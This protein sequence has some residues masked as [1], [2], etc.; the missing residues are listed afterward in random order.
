MK[1][2]KFFS[3]SPKNFTSSN[4][5][6]TNSS[7][8]VTY[9]VRKKLAKD[10]LYFGLTWI[11]SKLLKFS[12]E[13]HCFEQFVFLSLFQNY[14]FNPFRQI[15]ETISKKRAVTQG[16]SRKLFPDFFQISQFRIM[17]QGILWKLF[18][19]HF[20]EYLPIK[21]YFSQKRVMT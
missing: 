16:I 7:S 4:G 21:K 14:S 8:K 9:G 13:P 15:L 10:I 11:F 19:G 12:F 3:K 17:R 6:N 2:L 20:H 18:L 5:S 1:I